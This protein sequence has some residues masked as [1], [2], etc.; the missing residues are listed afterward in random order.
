MLAAFFGRSLG[1]AS[2][3]ERALLM[4]VAAQDEGAVAS[5]LAEAPQD[6]PRQMQV[7]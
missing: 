4:A 2:A 5:A 6:A 1:S 7:C 3:E